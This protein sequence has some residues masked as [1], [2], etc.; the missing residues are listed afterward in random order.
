MV[1]SFFCNVLGL[2]FFFL[3]LLSFL[4]SVIRETAKKKQIDKTTIMM[5]VVEY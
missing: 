5:T 1:W 2:N 4:F 3:I